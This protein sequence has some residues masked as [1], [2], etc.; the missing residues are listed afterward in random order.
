[1][2][3]NLFFFLFFNIHN[4][5]FIKKLKLNWA[6]SKYLF[7]NYKLDQTEIKDIFNPD[8]L[9][10]FVRNTVYFINYTGFNREIELFQPK[11]YH[12]AGSRLYSLELDF[13]CMAYFNKTMSEIFSTENSY[14]KLFAECAQ[15]YSERSKS[16][17]LEY[18]ERKNRMKRSG[19]ISKP[20]F[21]STNSRLGIFTVSILSKIQEMEFGQSSPNLNGNDLYLY[22]SE[23]FKYNSRISEELQITKKIIDS[24]S[25]TLDNYYSKLYGFQ[26]NS[27]ISRD[28]KKYIKTYL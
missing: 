4:G 28:L 16:E 25:F 13:I 17:F 2:N 8:S 12:E 6:G 9:F 27:E 14:E 19:I 15:E 3:S 26:L 24:N 23:K 18:I 10:E 11:Y 22:F 7:R 21:G 20:N 5:N 1:M